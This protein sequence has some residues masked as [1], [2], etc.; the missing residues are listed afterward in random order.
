MSQPLPPEVW[1]TV[2]GSPLNTRSSNA[3]VTAKGKVRFSI[4]LPNPPVSALL[5]APDDTILVCLLEQIMAISPHGTLRWR[6]QTPHSHMHPA[7]L[8]GHQLYA[9]EGDSI[10]IRDIHS[11]QVL[12]QTPGGHHGTELYRNLEGTLLLAQCSAGVNNDTLKLL[13]PEL[14]VLWSIPAPVKS[15]YRVLFW[16]DT[17]VMGDTHHLRGYTLQGQ[18]QWI[19][20]EAGVLFGAEATGY[21]RPPDAHASGEWPGPLM[22]LGDGRILVTFRHSKATRWILD[23]N[24]LSLESVLECRGQTFALLTIEGKKRVVTGGFSPH[25]DQGRY[26]GEITLETLRKGHRIWQAPLDSPPLTVMT[27]SGGHVLVTYLEDD[28]EWMRHRETFDVPP[29]S[30]KLSCFDAT[31]KSLWTWSAPDRISYFSAINS[32][33]TLFVIADGH[34]LAIE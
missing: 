20:S 32:S 10:V 1:P 25:G 5:I 22:D 6:E 8:I 31:G 12:A 23:L 21:I 17:V 4:P 14:K 9:H 27:D 28:R 33:G 15:L 7:C 34:L 2:H 30:C 29:S 24:R 19:V 13:T 18:L 11:G 26:P 3:V 16:Q